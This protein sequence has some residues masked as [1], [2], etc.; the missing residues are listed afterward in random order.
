M[1][2]LDLKD[3]H[4]S[5]PTSIEYRKY[6]RLISKNTLY[7]FT[8]LL[9]GSLSYLMGYAPRSFTKFMKPFYANLRSKGNHLVGY[10]HDILLLADTP[11]ELVKSS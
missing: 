5:V 3:A 11:Q 9:M 6:L 2:V 7:E 1:A 4:N 8:W 10:I